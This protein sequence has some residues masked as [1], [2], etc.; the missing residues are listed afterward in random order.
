V[1]TLYT[2]ALSDPGTRTRLT[3]DSVYESAPAWS[4]DGSSIAYVAAAAPWEV[5]LWDVATGS[6]RTIAQAPAGTVVSDL[7]LSPDADWVAFTLT[8]IDAPRRGVRVVNVSDPDTTLDVENPTWNDRVLG[9]SRG[10]TP[11]SEGS[12]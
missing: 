2:L 11:T 9:W 7:A 4:S 5:R 6:E 8:R 12:P 1:A 3:G 10:P